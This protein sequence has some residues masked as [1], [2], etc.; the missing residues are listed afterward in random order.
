M[1]QGSDDDTT[2][3]DETTA[4]GTETDGT[5]SGTSESTGSTGEP[6]EPVNVAFVTSTSHN[7][8]LGGLAGADE[9]C[10]DLAADAGLEGE[11]VAFLGITGAE[12]GRQRLEGSRG[13]VRTDGRPVLDLPTDPILYPLRIDEAGND[14]GADVEVWTGDR[15]NG[16]VPL[17]TCLEWT[18]SFAG[19]DGIAGYAD[20]VA[21]DFHDA[22]RDPC[23]FARRLYCFQLDHDTPV[24]LEPTDGRVA[25]VADTFWDGFGGIGAADS[26]CQT[27]A[28][29]AGLPGLYLA[30]LSGTAESAMSR[31]DLNGDPWVRPDQLAIAPTAADFFDNP[32]WD[33]PPHMYADGEVPNN[34]QT[35]WTGPAW[36]T[37]GVSS[38]TCNNW[39]GSTGSGLAGRTSR[40]DKTAAIASVELDDCDDSGERLYC[41][42]E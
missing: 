34:P 6:L 30:A 10:G 23:S 27:Q 5:T 4:G 42:Q 29:M 1:S 25:F 3:A 17:E 33:I 38:Q 19:D 22:T 21:T 24:E 36:D 16:I 28:D 7:G 26:I 40:S 8:A 18:S 37:T 20:A 15:S 31:F 9:I 35:A 2:T 32:L 14:V 41:L 11:F 12:N 39:Q 13:W